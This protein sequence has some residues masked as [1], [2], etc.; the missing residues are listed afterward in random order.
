MRKAE[1]TESGTCHDILYASTRSGK[2]G[3]WPGK[4]Q[5]IGLR[6]FG[7]RPVIENGKRK[8]SIAVLED[9]CS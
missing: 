3:F 4:S 1:W 8:I 9:V 6:E 7:G 2:K 5:G